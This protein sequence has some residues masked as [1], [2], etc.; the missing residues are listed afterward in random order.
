MATTLE[1]VEDDQLLSRVNLIKLSKRRKQ[2]ITYAVGKENKNPWDDL[3]TLDDLLTYTCPERNCLA[4]TKTAEAMKSHAL[5]A[6][7]QRCSAFFDKV[8]HQIGSLKP[9]AT[10]SS[11]VSDITLDDIENDSQIT[12]EPAVSKKKRWTPKNHLKPEE[13][14]V[15]L[16]DIDLSSSEETKCDNCD[17]VFLTP[18]AMIAHWLDSH[19]DELIMCTKCPFNTLSVKAYQDH[20]FEAHPFESKLEYMCHICEGSNV[21]FKSKVIKEMKR[22]YK[23]F[24][25]EFFRPYRCPADGCDRLFAFPCFLRTHH[26]QDH[27]KI[28]EVCDQCGKAV[29]NLKLHM[30]DMHPSETD[31]EAAQFKCEKCDFSSHVKRF[32]DHHSRAKHEK[33]KHITCDICLKTFPWKSNY[34]NHMDQYHSDKIVDPVEICNECGRGF[35]TK[36]SFF[37]HM[38]RKCRS[39]GKGSTNKQ[40]PRY[41]YTCFYCHEVVQNVRFKA[42]VNDMHPGEPVKAADVDIHDTCSECDSVFLNPGS[43]VVHMYQKHGVNFW[44]N[45]CIPCN[46]P[47]NRFHQCNPSTSGKRTKSDGTVIEKKSSPAKRKKKQQQQQQQQQQL[48]MPVLEEHHIY[49][50][51]E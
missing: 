13:A 49:Y 15:E 41:K 5:K 24:H 28:M 30:S 37:T 42:H 47:Y 25:G 1:K 16:L 12:S 23:E 6:H 3:T 29:K 36:T 46:V 51:Y 8:D 48:D 19:R 21:M 38:R 32:L 17:Q 14:L 50:V 22:H 4:V 39:S 20:H 34:Q 10:N 9:S 7:R 45:A 2:L 44:P 33:D 35:L 27:D 43:K 26:A 31:K 11:G 40:Q 18:S